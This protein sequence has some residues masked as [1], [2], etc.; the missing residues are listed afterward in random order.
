MAPKNPKK[1]DFIDKKGFLLKKQFFMF[2]V[3]TLQNIAKL[4][5]FLLPKWNEPL[6]VLLIDF[7]L[8]TL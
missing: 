7:L 2:P 6:L 5:T 1:L 8:L 3:A 4:I